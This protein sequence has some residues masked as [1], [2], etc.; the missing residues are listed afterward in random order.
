MPN[1][2][3]AFKLALLTD[4]VAARASHIAMEHDS[5]AALAKYLE[6]YPGADKAKHTVKKAPAEKAP[7]GKKKPAAK[8]AE[9]KPAAK[10]EPKSEVDVMRDM[11]SDPK[12]NGL[13]P[14]DEDDAETIADYKKQVD[15][16]DKGKAKDE[17]HKKLKN[18]PEH[19]RTDEETEFMKGETKSREDKAKKVRK[20]KHQ[21]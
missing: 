7:A 16:H 19:H 11:V 21:E 1:P 10:K 9:K 5:P 15:E 2:R 3:I 4:R 20:M 8:P 14:D 13:D 17:R 6:E 18:K 12:G